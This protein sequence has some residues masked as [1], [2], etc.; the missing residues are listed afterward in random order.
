MAATNLTVEDGGVKQG[1]S[2]LHQAVPVTWSQQALTH[3]VTHCAQRAVFPTTAAGATRRAQL[4][5]VGDCST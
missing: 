4:A 5:A 1:L 2:Q 3:T